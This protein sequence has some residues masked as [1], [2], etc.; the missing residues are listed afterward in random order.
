M[1]WFLCGVIMGIYLDQTFTIPNI[2][3]HIDQYNHNVGQGDIN[4]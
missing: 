3:E 4:S 2:Q 1:F